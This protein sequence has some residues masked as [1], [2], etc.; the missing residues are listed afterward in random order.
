MSTEGLPC[1]SERLEIEGYREKQP[2]ARDE[3][4]ARL[5]FVV[6]R[7]RRPS[8]EAVR[9][10]IPGKI[11]T[12]TSKE[13][14]IV[15]GRPSCGWTPS[16]VG[17]KCVAC[18]GEGVHATTN[19]LCAACHR[20]LPEGKAT[21]LGL[22]RQ[23]LSHAFVHRYLAGGVSMPEVVVRNYNPNDNC[24]CLREDCFHSF[25]SDDDRK[26]DVPRRCATY[27]QKI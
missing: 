5:S 19:A 4:L 24:L 17:V 20:W 27:N 25:F 16:A 13:T 3:K 12:T 23:K 11:P 2:I 15:C 18:P 10:R 14:A 21:H 22:E 26:A 9:I 8:A 7:S 1:L 6:H